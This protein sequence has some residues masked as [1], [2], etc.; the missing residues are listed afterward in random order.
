M[1]Q[2]HLIHPQ[3]N[4][5]IARAGHHSGILIADG[6]YPASTKKGPHSELVSLNLSPGVIN[7]CQAFETILSAVPIDKINV[8]GIDNNDSYALD[9]DP[10]IWIKYRKILTEKNLNLTLNPIPKW[11][12]YH[13]VMSDDHVLTVQT[14]EQELWAN[15]LLTIGCRI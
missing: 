5:I 1:L 2:H 10:P 13:T 3:I 12:F 6:N 14:A 11:D 4:E 9:D 7:C 15:I 8:M